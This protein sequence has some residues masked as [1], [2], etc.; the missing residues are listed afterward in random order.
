MIELL[1]ARKKLKQYF[2]FNSFFVLSQKVN[3]VCFTQFSVL[4]KTF[5]SLLNRATK[6]SLKKAQSEEDFGKTLSADRSF[7]SF[8]ISFLAEYL[9][10]LPSVSG[11]VL[12]FYCF[13]LS[14]EF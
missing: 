4:P 7:D 10:I 8:S 3:R 11:C 1:E 5:D 2:N 12:P 6:S 13:L 9:N 14:R